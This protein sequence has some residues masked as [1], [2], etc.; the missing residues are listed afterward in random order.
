MAIRKPWGIKLSLYYIVPICKYCGKCG[1]VLI[2]HCIH[3]HLDAIP[4]VVMSQVT[5]GTI[6]T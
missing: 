4:L 2:Y 5:A 1:L 3:V 6:T